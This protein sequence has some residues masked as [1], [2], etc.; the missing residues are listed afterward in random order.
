MVGLDVRFLGCT[1]KDCIFICDIIFCVF[2]VIWEQ[3]FNVKFLIVRIV[4]EH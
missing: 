2:V 4:K 1:M 3:K